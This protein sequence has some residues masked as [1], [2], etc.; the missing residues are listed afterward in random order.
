M[1]LL[2]INNNKW[3]CLLSH[4]RLDTTQMYSSSRNV[5]F[6]AVHNKLPTAQI[7]HAFIPDFI[8]SNICQLCFNSLDTPDHFLVTCPI[9]GL[10]G[11]LFGGTIIYCDP[12][13]WDLIPAFY[14][15]SI[16]TPSNISFWH[17]GEPVGLSFL[18]TSPLFPHK[19]L[20]P[21]FD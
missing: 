6:R 15:Q 19:S 9:R 14:L 11:P 16:P 5:W 21:A 18:T 17:F 20:G 2:N 3:L 1:L 4:C 12:M 13:Q 8:P 10:S 7:L